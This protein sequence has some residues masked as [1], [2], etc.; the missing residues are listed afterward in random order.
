[1]PVMTVVIAPLA[2]LDPAVS[3]DKQ[4]GLTTAKVVG[5]TV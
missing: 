4:D 2:K 3:Y 5:V 1:M